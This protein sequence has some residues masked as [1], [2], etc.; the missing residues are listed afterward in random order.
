MIHNFCTKLQNPRCR[1][2]WEIFVINYPMY[3]YY[4][5]VRDGKK[6][7]EGKINLSSFVFYPT[8]KENDKQQHAYSLFTM[9]QVIPNICTKF[10]NPRHSSSLEIFDTNFP[11]YYIGVRD[12]KRRQKLITA[13]C[14][15]PPTVYLAT[16][17]VYTKFEDSGSRRSRDFCD[18]N[19]Y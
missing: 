15:F 6:G 12:G 2:S 19:F 1:S 3:M 17:K 14:F 9:Q 7:K 16:F 8:N 11:M 10:Q 18:G 5:G 13:S 4:I